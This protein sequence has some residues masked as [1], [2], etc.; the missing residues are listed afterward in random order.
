MPA[1]VYMYIH[2][3][4]CTLHFYGF[5]YSQTW[6]TVTFTVV[7]SRDQNSIIM[8]FND[9]QGIMELYRHHQIHFT[10]HRNANHLLALAN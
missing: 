2:V 7:L 10:H 8:P 9:T 6:Y 1:C 3:Y 4:A 5:V